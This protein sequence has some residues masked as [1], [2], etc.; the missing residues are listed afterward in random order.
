MNG[1]S[2]SGKGRKRRVKDHDPMRVVVADDSVLLREGVARLLKDAGV[3]VVGQADDADQ[4]MRTVLA[5]Q[6]HAAIID[7]RMPP[8][9]TDDGFRAA[10]EIKQR[11]P[12]AGVLILSQYV[13]TGYALELISDTPAASAIFSRTGSPTSTGWRTQPAASQRAD[14]SSTP[15]SLPHLVGRRRLRDPLAA[16]TPREREVLQLMA[17]GRSNHGIAERLVVTERAVET[18]DEHLRQARAAP[19]I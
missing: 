8:T 5:Y 11:L 7:I 19:R 9:S 17:E 13:E 3:D 4:L 12:G 15:R 14:R 10:L 1:G 16:L 6:P 18:R 2:K